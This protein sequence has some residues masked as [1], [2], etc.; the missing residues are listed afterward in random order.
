MSHD[1]LT[2]LAAGAIS[3]AA[4]HASTVEI[5]SGLVDAL[6]SL[7]RVVE[8]QAGYGAAGGFDSLLRNAVLAEAAHA[9]GATVDLPSVSTPGARRAKAILVDAMMTGLMVTCDDAL[10]PRLDRLIETLTKDLF[11]L[12][13]GPPDYAVLSERVLQRIEI[14]DYGVEPPASHSM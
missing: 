8:V 9:G 7:R 1:Y 13:G 11:K 2:G 6:G 5:A 10:G 14:A 12:I 4:R 3:A